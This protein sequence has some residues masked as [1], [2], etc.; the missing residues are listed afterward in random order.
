MSIYPQIR[1]W[2]NSR[3]R[4]S[5]LLLLL[6]MADR[7]DELGVCWAGT[8]WLAIRSRLERRQTIRVIQA[9]E[10]AKEIIVIRSR[11]PAGGHNIVNHYIVSVG[12]DAKTIDAAYVRIRELIS[13]R[14]GVME[15]TSDTQDTRGSD[16]QDTRGSGLHDIRVVSYMSPDPS[17]DPEEKEGIPSPSPSELWREALDELEYQMPRATFKTH[18]INTTARSGDDGLIIHVRPGSDEWLN[19]RLHP[20]IERAVETIAGRHIPIQFTSQQ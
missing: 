9:L 11:R 8:N 20:I 19:G 2:E 15:D 12:A 4:G 16:T 14:G 18:L 3:Q 1:V 7:A 10:A 6:A 5:A 17:Y 13:L